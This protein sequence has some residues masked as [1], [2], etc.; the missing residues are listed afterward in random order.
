MIESGRALQTVE[1]HVAPGGNKVY[2]EVIKTPAELEYMRTA[3]RIT[4]AGLKASLE[5]AAEGRTDN[6]VVAAGFAAMYEAGSELTSIDGMC[7]VGHRAGLGPLAPDVSGPELRRAGLRAAQEMLERLGVQ[8]RHVIFGHTHRAGP[9]PADDRSEWRTAQGG[10]LINI[11]SWVY[12]ASFIGDSP[13]SSPY[14]P[15]FAAVV[16]DE[17]PSE[18][19]NLL[20]EEGG[21]PLS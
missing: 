19:V 3:G 17:G 18:L 4:W 20:D 13:G 10:E 9:L 7:M 11:G 6:D 16:E 15:G 1:E 21:G 14:R 2:V 5:A 8:A 12:E